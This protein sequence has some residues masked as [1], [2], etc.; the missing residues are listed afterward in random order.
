MLTFAYYNYQF[1]KILQ[2]RQGELFDT[3]PDP[4]ESFRRKQDIL[5]E[6]IRADYEGERKITLSTRGAP[7]CSVIATWRL[8][9]TA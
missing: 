5:D 1:G 8:R 7:R 6:L 9:R 2:P 3:L 4:E